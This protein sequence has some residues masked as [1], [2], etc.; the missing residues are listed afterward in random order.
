MTLVGK[1]TARPSEADNSP[2]N[3]GDPEEVSIIN[4]VGYGLHN[5]DSRQMI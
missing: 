1:R 4:P 2:T 3:A 5:F